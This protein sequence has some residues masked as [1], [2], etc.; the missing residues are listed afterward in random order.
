MKRNI[1]QPG[2]TYTVTVE[3]GFNWLEKYALKRF[4]P[5]AI[6]IDA[7]GLIW[8]MYYL[9]SHNWQMALGSALIGRLLSQLSV[10][11]IDV[12]RMSE[13][14]LG[15]I[16]LLHLHP[17]N[18]ITQLVGVIVLLFG[19]WQHSPELSLGGITMILLGHTYG[20]SKVDPRFAD[21]K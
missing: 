3:H 6:F 10:M 11:D 12:Q 2:W 19:F 14:V 16:A 20:W 5:R 17:I 1:A 7:I 9:W 4:H 8:F 18:L 21:E 15:K 13:T